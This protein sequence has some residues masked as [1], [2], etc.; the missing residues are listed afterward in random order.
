MPGKNVSKFNSNI[1]SKNDTD[2]SLEHKAPLCSSMCHCRF[3]RFSEHGSKP[4]KC[5][6]ILYTR[7]TY[8][9][10]LKDALCLLS[11]LFGNVFLT[12]L[13]LSIIN[14]CLLGL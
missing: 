5:T 4:H 8:D 11:E 1:W 6:L 7:P 12:D 2:D 14:L 3:S 13:S 10:P 9:I